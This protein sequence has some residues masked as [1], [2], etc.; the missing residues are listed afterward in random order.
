MESASNWYRQRD[1]LLSAEVDR[2]LGRSGI[3]Q[4]GKLLR[5]ELTP[6]AHMVGSYDLLLELP[7][8]AAKRLQSPAARERQLANHG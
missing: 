1:I 2:R 6:E 5:S 8:Y 3:Q 7:N 4:G